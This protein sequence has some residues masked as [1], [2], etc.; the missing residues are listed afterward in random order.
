[1]PD[2]WSV[3]S[4]NQRVFR[5]E[6]T[7]CGLVIGRTGNALVSGTAVIAVVA[8]AVISTLDSRH[9]CNYLVVVSFGWRY[10]NGS[11]LG[12]SILWRGVLC[13]FNTR[14]KAQRGLEISTPCIYGPSIGRF[15]GFS[16]DSAGGGGWS[17]SQLVSGG[18]STFLQVD[19]A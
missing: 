19:H 15:G 9:C 1:M 12:V 8:V 5:G 10:L 16:V 11:R 6:R 18:W 14:K 17:L 4:V 13:Q 2:I 7:Y 3:H